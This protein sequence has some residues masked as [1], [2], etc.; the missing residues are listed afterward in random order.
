MTEELTGARASDAEKVDWRARLSVWSTPAAFSTLVEEVQDR[1]GDRALDQS[2]LQ[3][4]R[5]AHIGMRC[6]QYLKADE[7]R[8]GP[9]PPDLELRFGDEKVACE[10]VEVLRP[11]RRRGEELKLDR[12]QMDEI[13]TKAQHIPDDEWLSAPVALKAISDEILKKVEKGYP[14][15][16]VLA[17]YLNLG[18]SADQRALSSGMY[19]AVSVGFPAFREIWAL[20]DGQVRVFR[21]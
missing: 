1:L 4:F 16:T 15:E 6:A 17:M 18:F 20:A 19:D 12:M 13:R 14:Q 3:F 2:G 9:D 10:A 7:I 11:G 8:L 21:P 5:D